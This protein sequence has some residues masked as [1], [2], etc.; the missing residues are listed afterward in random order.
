M[1]QTFWID[2]ISK[3]AKIN[4]NSESLKITTPIAHTQKILQIL[5]ANLS[6]YASKNL[7][8]VP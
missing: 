4:P 7:N 2:L 6:K 5:E 1:P 8:Y 3:C